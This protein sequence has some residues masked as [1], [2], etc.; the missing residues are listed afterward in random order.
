MFESDL[1]DDRRLAELECALGLQPPVV[2]ISTHPYWPGCW[3]ATPEHTAW[4][5]YKG[6]LRG[7]CARLIVACAT[8]LLKIWRA[9]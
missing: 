1:Q 4:L 8:L 5:A 9:L 6:S 2:L 7:R 3:T